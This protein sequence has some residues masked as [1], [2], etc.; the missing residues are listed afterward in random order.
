MSG[1][2][3]TQ[4]MVEEMETKFLE[5]IEWRLYPPTP[6]CF[7]RLFLRYLAAPP[8]IINEIKAMKAPTM[9]MSP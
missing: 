9:K 6:L 4:E 7:I 2:E 8:K 1:S 3:V 5:T